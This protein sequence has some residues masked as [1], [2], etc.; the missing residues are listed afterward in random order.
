MVSFRV[1]HPVSLVEIKDNKKLTRTGPYCTWLYKNYRM[2][3]R[4]SFLKKASILSGA[5]WMESLPPSIRQDLS[6]DPAAGRSFAGHVETGSVSKTDPL[7]G[8]V[9]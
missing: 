3:T 5:G 1:P 8:K 2:D 7:M 4:R 6:I 9:V